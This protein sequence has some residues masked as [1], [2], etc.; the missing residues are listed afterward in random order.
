MIEVNG[1]PRRRLAPL[2]L[3]RPGAD[4]PVLD[5]DARVREVHGADRE[6][7]DDAVVTRAV[8]LI[9]GEHYPPS[10]ATRSRSCRTS[11]VGGVLVGGTEKLRG[12]EDY[13]VPLA[14]DLDEALDDCVARARLRPLRRAGARARASASGSRAACSR[15]GSRTWAPTSASTRRSS[16]PSSCRRSRS[17]ARASASARPP[18]P[19]TLARLLAEDRD[20]V[21]V[22]MGRGGPA[23]PEVAEIAPTVESLLE[24]SRSGRHAASD[25]L[26]NA[27]LAR[28]DDDRLPAL[29]R[30]ARGRAGRLERRAPAP[31]SP[32]SARPTSSSSTGA[33]RRSRRSRPTGASSSPARTSRPSS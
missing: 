18:S 17:S 16:S 19:A 24:L 25:Y 27:A 28:R 10:C 20:V 32:P 7:G 21:V 3:P 2:P 11:V 8:A 6:R 29:R 9:D 33:A 5:R 30:R 31:S 4:H 12:G 22:A 23:E 14:A 26:E 13:G 15:A 1:Q